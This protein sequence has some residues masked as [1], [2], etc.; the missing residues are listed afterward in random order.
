MASP[1][2][3]LQSNRSGGI[4]PWGRGLLPSLLLV[5][6][7]IR[8]L[9][10]TEWAPAWLSGY[11]DDLL[12][13][14]LV[15]SLVLAVQRRVRGNPGWVLPISH[16]LVALIGYGIYFEGVLPRISSQAVADPLDLVMYLAG[17]LVFQC[18]L[19]RHARMGHSGS[20]GQGNIA[21]PGNRTDIHGMEFSPQP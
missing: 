18:C 8:L 7:L 21:G 1:M 13:L 11:G 4:I 2:G 17:Y 9:E 10:T 16:G 5:F 6:F 19:N 20:D 12:C 15:L 3:I 14:P